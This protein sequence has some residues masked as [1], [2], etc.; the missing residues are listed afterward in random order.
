MPPLLT[1]RL[2]IP[3]D[4]L[5][6]HRVIVA[7]MRPVEAELVE[8]LRARYA[9]LI[10]LVAVLESQVVGHILFTPITIETAEAT[11]PGLGLG[12]LAVQPALQNQGIGSALVREG[13]AVCRAQGHTRVCVLGHRDYYPRFG[14]APAAIFGLH[15]EH[16]ADLDDFMVQA[17]APGALDGV[18]GVI[19]YLPE[20]D[21]V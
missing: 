20:F 2:E 1:I 19:R 8:A 14:F 21:G 15:W 11:L 9:G 18:Q 5:A 12:P 6:I 16:K 17:L 4:I 13:L 7:A 10:S 3:A